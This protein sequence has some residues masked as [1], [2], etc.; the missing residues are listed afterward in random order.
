MA[1]KDKILFQPIT[2]NGLKIKN[3]F[4]M[5]SMG[6]NF[7][8]PDHSVSDKLC[9]Y[10]EARAKGG[11]GLIMMEYSAVDE[12]GLSAPFQLGVFSDSH[13]PGMSRL[14][15]IAH[16]YN[17]KIGMQLQHGGIQAVC[18][19]NGA[20]GPSAVNGAREMTK[21]DMQKVINAFAQ[22]A[23][24]ARRAG[25]DL[26]ELHGAHG[27]LLNQFLSPHYNKRTDEYG[28]DLEG[29]L[30]FPLEVYRAVRDAVGPDFPVNFRLSGDERMADG[31]TVEDKVRI[32][33]RLA[34]EGVNAIHVSGGLL[35]SIPYVITP[36]AIEPGYNV[37][38]AEKI[39]QAVNIPVIVVG[40]LHDPDYAE[41]LLKSGK[42]DMI[43]LGR[44]IYV[45][46]EYPNKVYSG[47]EK[48]IRKCLYCV[49]HCLDIPAGCVQNPD[50][51]FETVHDYT[52]ARQPRKVLVIGG[53]PGGLEAAL[54][55]ARRGHGVVLCEKASELGGNIRLAR[56]PPFKS[57]INEIVDYRAGQLER[58]GVDIRLNTEADLE[59]VHEINPQAVVVASGS[60]PL[61]PPI[62]GIRGEGVVT[63]DDVL[64]GKA[65]PS[66]RVVI[67]GGGMVGVETAEAI[68]ERC[69]KV[70]VVEMRD[71]V[72]P[73]MPN[74]TKIV[75]MERIGGK[76][77]ILT[78][79]AVKG[80]EFPD[81]LVEKNGE[82]S[83]LKDCDMVI[84]AAG[85][86]S[87][88][89]ISG[90]IAEALP[91]VALYTVGDATRARTAWQAIQ[92]GNHAGRMI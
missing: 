19:P 82:T 92:E 50:L 28:G 21:D 18:A 60:E 79:T 86:R 78:G 25:M 10:I 89:N 53:G 72:A 48:D 55:A 77:E 81:V 35:E 51:G 84:V 3:R 39:K 37:P 22:A 69:E 71:T 1:C 42:A 47:H 45:D 41:S 23:A 44:A 85:Y 73:D 46:P 12:S 56:I 14:V 61:I 90:K 7:A 91:N 6:T 11:V 80:V 57:R 74:I 62:P 33:K 52:P 63:A 49:Q 31:C 8:N 5:P 67:I 2:I 70:T 58:L 54:T 83:R 88:E 43:A 20:L 66:G 65:S 59:L 75:M 29:F 64:N 32:A 15:E 9:G 36:G 26:V 27:Y 30:R 87:A 34:E 13:I 76:V 17:A 4:V 40:K 16:R 68:M 38:A 24:R